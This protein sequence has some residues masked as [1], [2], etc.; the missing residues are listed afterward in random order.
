MMHHIKMGKLSWCASPY[1]QRAD[2]AL[3]A[4]GHGIT[5]VCMHVHKAKA[6]KMVGFLHEHGI[7]SARVVPGPCD[8]EAE[9]S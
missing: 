7:E 1:A 9:G 4:K 6:K 2:L 5:L 3:V 8:H